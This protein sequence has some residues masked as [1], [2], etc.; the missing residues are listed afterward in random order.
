MT[1]ARTVLVIT[2]RRA[3]VPNE[4]DAIVNK[5]LPRTIFRYEKV[6]DVYDSFR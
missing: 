5:T 3:E 4:E 2:M 6:V 1:L